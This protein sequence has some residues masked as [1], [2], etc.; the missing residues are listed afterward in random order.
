MPF[1]DQNEMVE[2]RFAHLKTP[3][4]H[5]VLAERDGFEAKIAHMLAALSLMSGLDNLENL[6]FRLGG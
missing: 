4:H 6:A 1:A 2:P 3:A 5:A